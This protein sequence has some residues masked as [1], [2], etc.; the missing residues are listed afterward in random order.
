MRERIADGT[1]RL[2]LSSDRWRR[3]LT[4]AERAIQREKWLDRRYRGVLRRD[5]SRRDSV[6]VRP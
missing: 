3:E 2:D 1:F 4:P 5:L 6:I